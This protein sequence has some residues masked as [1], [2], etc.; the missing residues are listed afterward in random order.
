M[1]MTFI[2]VGV[3]GFA[4][5]IHGETQQQ[6]NKE[7]EQRLKDHDKRFQHQAHEIERIRRGRL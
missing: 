4:F 6:V 2:S 1:I 3:L 7:I 5:W